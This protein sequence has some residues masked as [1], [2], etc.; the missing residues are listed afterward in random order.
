MVYY[1]E[2]SKKYT[3]TGIKTYK[4]Q[5]NEFDIDEISLL[6][7]KKNCKISMK[8]KGKDTTLRIGVN[9]REYGQYTYFIYFFFISNAVLS[10]TW[11]NDE[12]FIAEIR[13]YE[14]A[15]TFNIELNFDD[16]NLEIILKTNMSFDNRESIKLK[17]KLIK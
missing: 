12:N 14:T 13:Y 15:F 8:I 9:T 1:N 16:D 2:E 10:G 3:N 17:G 4:L 7:D 5:K 11:K 6:F